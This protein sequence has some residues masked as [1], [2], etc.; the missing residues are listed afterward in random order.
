MST[1]NH[2][3]HTWPCAQVFGDFLCSNREAIADKMVLEI[4][5]GA[6]GV[7]GLA[8]AKLGA[9]RVWMT[10]HPSLVDAL[11]T[12]QENID[13]NGV[14]A[15]C[16]VT[17]LDWDSRASVTQIIDLIGDRLDLIVASDV[18]FD[19]STFRP[20]V[21]TLAQLLIKY[22]HAVVWF[23]YQ[24]RDDNWTCAPAL[25]KYPFLQTTLAKRVETDNQ[26]IDI[27]TMIRR[28]PIGLYAG[29]EGGATGSKLV[30]IDADNDRRL[31]STAEG[32]NF[33][34]TDYTVVCKRIADWIT[35]VF[36][37][38]KLEISQLKALG[39]GLSGAEDEEFNKK[40]VDHFRKNYGHITDN[41]YLMSDSVMTVLAN[42]PGEE[43]GIVLIAGTGSSCRMKRK[44]GVI[45]GAGGW[46]HQIGD[47]G[48]A[49]WIA[50]EAIQMLFDAEDGFVPYYNTN[51]IKQL[52][53]A[54]YNIN[55]KT[56]ILDYLYSKFE[57][58]KIADFTVS[59]A[60]RTDDPAIAE[61]FRRAGDILGRHVVVVS[62]QLPEEDRKVLHI[63]EIGGVFQS[64]PAIQQGFMNAF[65][66]SGVEKLMMY[67]PCDSPAVGAAVL[68][69]KEH[70]A[71][72]LQQNTA[73]KV[74]REI[75]FCRLVTVPQV[76][77]RM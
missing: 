54:H 40:F 59:L 8:A 74:S 71:I 43:N 12:L 53:F 26:T 62:R 70:K 67:E 76:V 7:C 23:A 69:A 20:L 68:A 16:S 17:G 18:F 48:S 47:G 61:V 77:P 1:Q 19:P 29:I 57:K 75:V 22:E 2:W 3:K 60:T 73:K 56:R 66:E 64:W 31:L 45:V 15:C 33:F 72:Y 38:E 37:E 28:Q 25:A 6:T 9:H 55:D 52:L 24:Q 32:T 4:G 41:F 36:R 49:F 14:A 42:F 58:H 34:L 5:A 51:V 13:A 27:F 46:G 10:D 39:L 35:Q 65:H 50:R 63:V 21:D 30:V 11:Q 44:D